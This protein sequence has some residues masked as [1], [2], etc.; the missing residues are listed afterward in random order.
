MVLLDS[1]GDPVGM[2]R[3]RSVADPAKEFSAKTEAVLIATER[4]SLSQMN[5]KVG[6]Q[7]LW[8]RDPLPITDP[9]REAR[10]SGY[11]ATIE[12]ISSEQEVH[13]LTF[14]DADARYLISLVTASRRQAPEAWQR[15]TDDMGTV[16][17]SFTKK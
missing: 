16:M 2:L 1:D 12:G 13:I 7:A 17:R 4:A 14:R 11:P 15:N 5:V 10:G 9:F 6:T 3:L 8:T